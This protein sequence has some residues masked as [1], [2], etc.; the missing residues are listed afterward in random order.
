MAVFENADI[1]PTGNLSGVPYPFTR[2]GCAEEEDEPLAQQ[3][4]AKNENEISF[5]RRADQS[6]C[7]A[8]N[9]SARPPS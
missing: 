6:S 2:G 9:H 5:T 7:S 1:I 4:T 8:G 3:A